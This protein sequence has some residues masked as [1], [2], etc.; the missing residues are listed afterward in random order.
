MTIDLSWL[1]PLLSQVNPVWGGIGA[2]VLYA[3]Q[4]LGGK[5]LDLSGGVVRFVSRLLG[6]KSAPTHE[7]TLIDLI[8]AQI[9][10]ELEGERTPAPTPAPGPSPSTPATPPE[11]P[12]D[13]LLDRWLD[14]RRRRAGAP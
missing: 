6:L 12:L 4:L 9:R 10:A 3:L 2:V 1:I 8:L 13:R 5:K 7:G 14:L 11:R